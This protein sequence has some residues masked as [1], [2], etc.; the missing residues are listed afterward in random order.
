MHFSILQDF[1][2]FFVHELPLLLLIGP[3]HLLSPTLY[4]LY[5]HYFLFTLSFFSHL[6]AV[7]VFSQKLRLLVLI[8]PGNWL[9]LY[10]FVFELSFYPQNLL[11]PWNLHQEKGTGYLADINI[12]KLKDIPELVLFIGPDIWNKGFLTFLYIISIRNDHLVEPF[13]CDLM[14]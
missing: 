4:V 5:I 10:L 8:Q 6:L 3:L 14:R 9:D 11:Y 2:M 1:F 13:W 7:F 12:P